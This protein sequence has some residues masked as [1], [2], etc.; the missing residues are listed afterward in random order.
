MKWT[1]AEQSIYQCISSGLTGL[2]RLDWLSLDEY[3][4][5]LYILQK[6]IDAKAIQ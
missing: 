2:K 4:N 1:L 3:E 5:I 6:Y